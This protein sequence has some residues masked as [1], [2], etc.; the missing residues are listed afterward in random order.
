V[1]TAT[2]LLVAPSATHNTE[3]LQNLVADADG[4]MI[5]WEFQSLPEGFA[6]L[7]VETNHLKCWPRVELP[8]EAP[9]ARDDV[10][11]RDWVVSPVQLLCRTLRLAPA[12]YQCFELAV[13]SPKK[14]L[15]VSCGDGVSDSDDRDMYPDNSDDDC[16]LPTFKSVVELAAAMRRFAVV[17]R[18]RV[19][20]WPDERTI[21]VRRLRQ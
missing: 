17:E 3:L 12:C 7:R 6:A 21:I 9:G 19:D 2:E 16:V 18:L 1:H 8:P 4:D 10:W 15:T 11:M 5:A 13:A 14:H 20:V